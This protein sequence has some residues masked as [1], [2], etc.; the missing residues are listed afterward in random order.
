MGHHPHCC[1]T[2]SVA[3]KLLEKLRE[4]TMIF[5]PEKW[6][7]PAPGEMIEYIEH[8][9]KAKI[10][11]PI[12]SILVFRRHLSPLAVYKYLAARFARPTAFRH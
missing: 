2:E 6:E 12:G 4:F 5:M 8:R 1:L 9:P 11:K 10:G 7:K 3:D